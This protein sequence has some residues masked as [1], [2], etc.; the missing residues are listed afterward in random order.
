MRLQC[1]CWATLSLLMTGIQRDDC[2]RS[3]R[4]GARHRESLQ[5]T[6]S[7]LPPTP[8]RRRPQ[9]GTGLGPAAPL[10]RPSGPAH[11]RYA[12]AFF[13]GRHTYQP[14]PGGK[15]TIRLLPRDQWTVLI[16][17][18]HP[19]YITWAEFDTN[20]NR[21][22]ELELEKEILRKAAQYFAKEMGR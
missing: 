2:V 17:D 12:G 8:P 20:H 4:L 19:G 6:R 11:P 1:V 22:A 5:P 3:H 15:S 9:R 21:L 10:P 16:T 14:G 18:A 13:Y 7:A